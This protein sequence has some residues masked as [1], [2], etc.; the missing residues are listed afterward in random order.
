[1][2]P[3]KINTGMYKW[4]LFFIV[5]T[6]ISCGR[7]GNKGEVNIPEQT[8]LKGVREYVDFSALEP[9]FH[10]SNDS[11]Y[12][13]NFWATTCPPCLKEL[14]WFQQLGMEHQDKKL[15]MLFINIDGKRHMED[16]LFPFIESR[17]INL[18]IV[19]LTDPNANIWTEA[20]NPNWY[21]AL[22]YTIIYNQKE[23]KYYFGAFDN[24][25]HLKKEVLYFLD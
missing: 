21:G 19:A 15:E 4:L 25:D 13:I 23:R 11:T 2:L 10:K 18:P 5:A 22:P 16:R 3:I 6:I 8:V 1:M 17:N 7:T 14:P 12:V 24:Y 20:V 9:M